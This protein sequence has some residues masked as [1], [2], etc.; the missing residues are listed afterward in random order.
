[1][2]VEWTGCS[3]CFG[4]PLFLGKMAACPRSGKVEQQR[5]STICCHCV[6]RPRVD[7]DRASMSQVS[8]PR[9][10][11]EPSG[12]VF[13]CLAPPC[14]RVT[15]RAIAGAASSGLSV[16]LGSARLGGC[17]LTSVSCSVF[18]TPPAQ[19]NEPV[20]TVLSGCTCRM[21]FGWRLWSLCI[22]DNVMTLSIRI[23][24]APSAR[25]ERVGVKGVLPS[26][27]IRRRV[28][29]NNTSGFK[30]ETLRS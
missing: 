17:G 2:C 15:V 25:L 7:A 14:S 18:N 8:E 20:R 13:V 1:M 3:R 22:T 27:R 21:R 6:S 28:N 30:N 19:I 9:A 29:N 26:Q 23:L 10:V 5:G 4:L 16:L 24:N 12:S 11:P